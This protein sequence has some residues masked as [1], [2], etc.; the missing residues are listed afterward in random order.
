MCRYHVLGLLRD[1]PLH[2]YALAQEYVR[3]CGSTVALGALY[4]ELRALTRDGLVSRV[5]GGDR[6]DAR[7]ILYRLSEKGRLAFASWLVDDPRVIL[8]PDSELLQRSIFLHGMERDRIVEIIDGWEA[9]MMHLERWLDRE[10]ERSS[11]LGHVGVTTSVRHALLTRRRRHLMEDLGF[12]A[13]LRTI[14]G[15]PTGRKLPQITMQSTTRDEGAPRRT[16]G[17]GQQRDRSASAPVQR[18]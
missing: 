8:C 17:G 10:I 16:G 7:R 11:S 13:D 15:A 9:E 5:E 1:G 2:G 6:Q 4:R 3:L 14:F 18:T 12:V